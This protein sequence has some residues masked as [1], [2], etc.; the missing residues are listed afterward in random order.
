MDGRH[1]RWVIGHPTGAHDHH[2]ALTG[3][4]GAENGDPLADGAVVA[5][6]RAN[7]DAQS[8]ALDD[9]AHELAAVDDRRRTDVALTKDA[10]TRRGANE[11]VTTVATALE[12]H[13]TDLD[14]H[15]YS[16]MS[17]DERKATI[18]VLERLRE[19]C[20]TS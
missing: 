6:T 19:S 12:T 9:P 2:A 7:L 11:G 4:E 15:F 13:L 17:D 10:P 8:R 14:A 20:S 16:A 1:H 18:P 5:G 3:I